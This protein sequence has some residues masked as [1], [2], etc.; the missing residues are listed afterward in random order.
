MKYFPFKI[1]FLSIFLPPICYILT[2]QILEGYFQKREVSKLNHLIIQD[3]EAL[4]EGRYTIKEEI[5]RNLGEYL[6]RGL[7]YTLGIRTHILVK[8]RDDRIL[9]PSQFKKAPKDLRIGGVFSELPTESLNYI[10]VAAENYRLLNEGLILSITVRIKHN[11]WLSNSVLVFYVFI[12]V[13]LLKRYITKGIRE[14]K[15]QEAK[16]KE[17]IQRYSGRLSLAESRLKEVEV[18]E[19]DYLKK[20]TKLKKDKKDLSEDVDGLLEEMENLDVGLGEQRHLKEEMEFEVLQLREELDRLKQKE[21]TPR[22]KKKKI[23]AASKRLKSLYKNLI[24]TE[25]AIEGFQYLTDEFQ[26]KAEEIIHSL[27]EDISLVSAKRK[28]FGK[29]GK[30]NVLEVDFSYSGRLYFQKDSQ[31]KT[32]IV[33]IG[34][35]NTQNKDI[36]FIERL[37]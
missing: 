8:T 22:G 37:R 4:Y 15:D 23:E 19:D 33:A 9:Y 2:L 6:G 11:S 1:L 5:S 36:A 24:F 18:K 34:T 28:V 25:R 3:Y 21:Q 31:A 30:M 13:L 32:K 14:E 10:A 12:F 7:K 29:G 35:K 20:I 16:Q 26:L 27:N 17:L